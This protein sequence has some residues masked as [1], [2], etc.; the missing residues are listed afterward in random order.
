MTRIAASLVIAVTLA[1]AVN[2]AMLWGASPGGA[3]APTP[4]ATATGTPMPSAPPLPPGYI[5]LRV[6]D[7]FN[8]TGEEEPGEH[9][10]AGAHFRAGCEDAFVELTTNMN[11]DYVGPATRDEG[12]RGFEC[13]FL[14]R[15]FGWLPTSPLA[16]PVPPSWD[17]N[18]PIRYFVHVLGPTVMELH[19]ETILRG[20]PEPHVTFSR[21]APPFTGTNVG[22]V[23]S[24]AEGIGWTLIIVGSEQRDGCPSKGDRFSVIMNGVVVGTFPFLPGSTAPE[25]LRF[26]AGGD[27]MRLDSADADGAEIGGLDCSVV[28]PHAGGL[29]PPSSAIYVLSDEARPGCGTP[30]KLVRFTKDGRPL[31]PLVPWYAGDQNGAIEFTDAAPRSIKPPNTGS[32]GLLPEVRVE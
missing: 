32:A 11:G 31:E 9:G 17:A 13:F 2:A 4:K 3:A 15:E 7:D 22:C 20:L 14:E 18:G 16:L 24:F 19:A 29:I 27:S 8:R 23:E 6:V 1:L 30:G 5:H 26:V 28:R 25:E 12:G 10:I 21:V